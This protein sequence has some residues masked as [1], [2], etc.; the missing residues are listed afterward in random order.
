MYSFTHIVN[1]DRGER[2]GA[3][4][5]AVWVGWGRGVH[6]TAKYE[7]KRSLIKITLNC[8]V[9]GVQIPTDE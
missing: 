4:G 2:E 7:K 8:H 1:V 6:F 3:Q 5:A 9:F